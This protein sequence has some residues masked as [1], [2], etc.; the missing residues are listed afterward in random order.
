ML[1]PAAAD[2]AADSNVAQPA[3]ADAEP[4]LP[5]QH[6]PARAPV[7]AAS[8]DTAA[9]GP[10][11]LLSECVPPADAASKPAAV[12]DGAAGRDPISDAVP[13]A[14][15]DGTLAIGG[16]EELL[17]APSPSPPPAV[18]DSRQD[19]PPPVNAGACQEAHTAP[20]STEVPAEAQEK[21]AAAV[22]EELE[23][24]D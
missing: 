9:Q 11:A 5:L 7:T 6:S 13:L 4:R 14:M 23:H 21:T 2:F 1:V 10:A 22:A 3:V 12:G 16:F 17:T 24:N 20:V 18:G 15:G 8:P 19:K